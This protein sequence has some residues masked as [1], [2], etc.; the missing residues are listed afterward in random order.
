[1]KNARE[2]LLEASRQ[3][4]HNNGVGLLAGYDRTETERIVQGLLNK[5]KE[6]EARLTRSGD[7]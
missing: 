6:L 5:I 3:Y 7:E 4:C 1:M 2:T